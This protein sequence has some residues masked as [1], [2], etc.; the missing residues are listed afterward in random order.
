MS[1]PSGSISTPA[2]VSSCRRELPLGHGFGRGLYSGWRVHNSL[3][4]GH[5]SALDAA[6]A[7]AAATTAARAG[8]AWRASWQL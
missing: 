1:S 3:G 6:A 2:C 7:T 8:G 4:N 5:V